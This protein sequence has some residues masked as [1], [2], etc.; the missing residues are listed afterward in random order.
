MF[1]VLTKQ[2]AG[3]DYTGAAGIDLNEM[4][5]S[6]GKAEQWMPDDG[7]GKTEVRLNVLAHLLDCLYLLGHY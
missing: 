5:K 2:C 6:A 1:V 7:S 3:Q 4:H